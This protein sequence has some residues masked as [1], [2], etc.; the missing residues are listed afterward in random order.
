MSQYT[1]YKTL[2]RDAT[3]PDWVKEAAAQADDYEQLPL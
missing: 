3:L 2:K 1:D